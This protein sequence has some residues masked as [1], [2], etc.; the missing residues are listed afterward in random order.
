MINSVVKKIKHQKEKLVFYK[1]NV[2]CRNLIKDQS[3]PIY[4]VH[5]RKTAGTTINF[6][7]LSNAENEDVNVFYR[8]LSQKSNNRLISNSKVFVGWNNNLINEG[9]YSYAFSHNPIHKLNLP[10]NI[11]LFTCLRDPVKRVLSHYNMLKFYQLKGS[12][13]PCMKVEG[14]WIGDSIVDFISLAPKEHI[15]NQLYMFSKSFSIDETLEKLNELDLVMFTENLKEDLKVL[16]GLTKWE[17][18]VSNQKSYGHKEQISDDHLEQ[19]RAFMEPEYQL[20]QKFKT[21]KGID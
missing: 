4:H 5:I 12:K 19:L 20:I 10:S 15:H 16:E 9:N 1:E 18:P 8:N 14:G 17:L 13:H 2:E 6:A 11:F 7:F 21:L 3:L